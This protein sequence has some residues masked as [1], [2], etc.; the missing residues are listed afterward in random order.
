M[1]N[2][3]RIL[4]AILAILMSSFFLGC[5]RADSDEVADAIGTETPP[6]AG[7][8]VLNEVVAKAAD[9]GPDWVELYNR[10]EEELSLDGYGLQDDKDDNLFLFPEGLTLAP[11]EYLVIEGKNSAEDI[12]FPFGFGSDEAVRLIDV[13]GT[14]VDILDWEE[15]EAPVGQSYGRYPDGG[16]DM[17]TLESATYGTS[18]APIN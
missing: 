11:G 15:G 16:E 2:F 13:D 12:H 8:L 5:E 10:G 9:D 3:T 14:L 1:K 18:N 6:I 4:G 17:G 7:S